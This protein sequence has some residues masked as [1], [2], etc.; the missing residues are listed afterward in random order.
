MIDETQQRRK[1]GVSSSNFL[2]GMRLVHSPVRFRFREG[3]ACV[4]VVQEKWHSRG[5]GRDKYKSGGGQVR[6]ADSLSEKYFSL[7]EI[8]SK[9]ACVRKSLGHAKSGVIFSSTLG[10][11]WNAIT[12]LPMEEDYEGKKIPQSR[13]WWSPRKKS[14]KSSS[15]NIRKNLPNVLKQIKRFLSKYTFWVHRVLSVS[16]ISAR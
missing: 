7:S 10:R 16:K 6:G 8:F 13:I 9:I 3:N 2:R 15:S 14:G 11:G 4:C 12:F 5:I 1:N